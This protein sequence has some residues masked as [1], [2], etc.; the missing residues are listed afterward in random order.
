MGGAGRDG[1]VGWRGLA[2]TKDTP[3]RINV[4][5][6]MSE[7]RVFIVFKRIVLRLTA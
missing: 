7:V 6:G 3:A 1:P 5:I 4:Q 2:Q